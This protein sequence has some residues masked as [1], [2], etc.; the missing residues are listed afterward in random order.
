VFSRHDSETDCVVFPHAPAHISYSPFVRTCIIDQ[1]P[2]LFMAAYGV[3]V[4]TP[5][6]LT[7][8]KHGLK[9]HCPEK[10]CFDIFLFSLTCWNAFDRPRHMQTAIVRQLYR[11]GVVY[12]VVS[13]LP[14]RLPLRIER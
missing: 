3:P 10:I 4:R 6:P 8:R 13:G 11:D 2:T 12:F 14:P 7:F 9:Y 1:K 5:P